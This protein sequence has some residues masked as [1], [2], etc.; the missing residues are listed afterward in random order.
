MHNFLKFGDSPRH[1]LVLSLTFSFDRRPKISFV[2]KAVK[3]NLS[4][5]DRFSRSWRALEHALSAAG[6]LHC[7]AK[8]VLR[9]SALSEAVKHA[10]RFMLVVEVWFHLLQVHMT[11]LRFSTTWK[12]PKDF[13]L[14]DGWKSAYSKTS[15]QT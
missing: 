2:V 12:L 9:F 1:R 15:Q 4:E 10:R 11:S 6:A 13:S 5:R 8:T 14:T 7:C 3:V